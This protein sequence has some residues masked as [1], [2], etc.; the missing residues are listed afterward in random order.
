MFKI[1]SIYI[2]LKIYIK[3][4]IW[5]VVVRP[6]YIQDA[7]FL[8]VKAQRIKWLGH[9]Q[10]MDQ[11]R[12]NRNLLDWKPMGTRPA[13]KPGQRWQEDIMEDLK[14]LK[15]KNW[16]ETAQDRRTWR[17]MAEKAKPHKGLQCQ[18]MMMIHEGQY[19][20]LIISR[21]FC[22]DYPD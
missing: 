11:A 20:F 9:I 22:Y 2:C 15:V 19:R 13:G 14:T 6:S 16:K 8:K 10:R 12:P 17:G 5:R 4:N 7:G 1:L 21:S 18:M 3:C